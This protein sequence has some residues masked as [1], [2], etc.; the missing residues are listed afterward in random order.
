MNVYFCFPLIR[1]A[2]PDGERYI[3]YLFLFAIWVLIHWFMVGG[4]KDL[5]LEKLTHWGVWIKAPPLI[6]CSAR[7]QGR[8]GAGW[9]AWPS[10]Q[11][12]PPFPVHILPRRAQYRRMAVP[13]EGEACRLMRGGCAWLIPAWR[14][15]GTA[16]A[17]GALGPPGSKASRMWSRCKK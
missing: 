14:A 8:M 2:L 16:W 10:T 4:G 6:S 13:P 7:V 12:F 3:D 5:N 9:R 1:V 11:D 17:F 15:A